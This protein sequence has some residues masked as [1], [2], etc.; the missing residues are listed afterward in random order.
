MLKILQIID[1]KVVTLK[2]KKKGN[3]RRQLFH[4]LRLPIYNINS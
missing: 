3:A 1:N 4:L 2:M